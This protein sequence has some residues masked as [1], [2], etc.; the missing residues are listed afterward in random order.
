MQGRICSFFRFEGEAAQTRSMQTKNNLL[1]S[2][3][4]RIGVFLT[5]KRAQ[6]LVRA[7][8]HLKINTVS[9]VDSQSGGEVSLAPWFSECGGR[10]TV[11]TVL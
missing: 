3:V 1:R 11:L 8:I 4:I 5:E 6:F 10:K 9:Q 7:L 2:I